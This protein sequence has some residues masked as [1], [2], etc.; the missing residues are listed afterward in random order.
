VPRQ[1]SAESELTVEQ[2]DRLDHCIAEFNKTWDDGFVS[3]G[4]KF[5]ERYLRNELCVHAHFDGPGKSDTEKFCATFYGPDHT[6]TPILWKDV[7]FIILDY[8]ATKGNRPADASVARNDQQKFVFVDI[9]KVM[10]NGQRVISGTRAMVRLQPLND[11][12]RA[13]GNSLYCSAL[14]GLCV[15]R[16]VL[17]DGEYDLESGRLVPLKHECPDQMVKARAQVADDLA[18]AYTKV[19]R[20]Q[21]WAVHAIDVFGSVVVHLLPKVATVHVKKGCDKLIKPID[22][23]IGPLNLR[24]TPVKWM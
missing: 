19:E 24:P 20:G 3:S 1:A 6:T 11:C 4:S 10:K 12:L 22:I 8:L 18:N 21:G 15:F 13:S 7:D 9:V 23:M 17:A 2:L 5:I 16:D 14:N